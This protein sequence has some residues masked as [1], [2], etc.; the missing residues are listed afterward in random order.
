MKDG[1]KEMKEGRPV[2]KVG[3]VYIWSLDYLKQDEK[4]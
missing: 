2:P 3:G 1:R 4:K